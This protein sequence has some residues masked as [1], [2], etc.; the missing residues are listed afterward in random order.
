MQIA[1]KLR[2]HDHNIDKITGR[3]RKN[4]N[5]AREIDLKVFFAALENKPEDKNQ[6]GVVMG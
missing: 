3:I 2:T 4:L 5:L 6:N 1:A